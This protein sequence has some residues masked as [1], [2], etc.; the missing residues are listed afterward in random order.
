M[1]D[2]DADGVAV[3]LDQEDDRIAVEAGEV[4]GLPEFAF[5]GGPFAAG[6]KGDFFGVGFEIA[7]GMGA[8]D[9][10]EVLGASG[11]TAADDVEVCRG[12]VAGHLAATAHGVGSGTDGLEKHLFLGDAEGE[13]QSAIAIVE[14]EPVETGF[15][16]HTGGDLDCFVASGRD[17]EV[18]LI[19]AFE[20]DLAV[21]NATTEI[22]QAV[23]AKQ[24]V[25]GQ[26]L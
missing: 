7:G 5:A 10:L 25:G 19:L 18:D 8:T 2:R 22:H 16:G 9:G 4:D 15:A 1:L 21:V 23:G 11:G 12:P 3:V 13:G 17:L 26:N 14:M 20:K 24:F 6:D